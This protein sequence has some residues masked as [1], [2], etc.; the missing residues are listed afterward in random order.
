[1]SRLLTDKELNQ[2]RDLVLPPGQFD[3]GMSWRTILGTLF[4]ALVMLPAAMYMHLMIGEASLGPAATWVTVILFLEMAKRARSFLKPAVIFL[5]M[6]MI[7]MV[8]GYTPAEGFFWRQYLVQSD[9]VRSFGLASEFPTWYAPND[10]EVLD[11]QTFFHWA[12]FIPLV[13]LFIQQVVNKVDSLILGYGLFKL[14]SDIEKLP[15]PM[16][17]LQASGV[18]A[19]ADTGGREA[20]RWRCFSIATVIGMVFGLIYTGIPTITSTFLDAPYQ[21]LPIPWLDTTRQTEVWFPAT[22]TGMAFDLGNFFLGMAMPFFA[23]VGSF[24]GVIITVI[25]NPLLYQTGMLTTWRQG[26]SAVQTLFANNM[27]FYLSFSMGISVVIAAIGIYEV[28]RSLRSKGSTH[29][30]DTLARAATPLPGKVK[31]GDLSFFLVI[32]TYLISCS[33]YLLMAGYLLNWDFQ[34]SKLLW[35]LLFFSLIYVP[36]VSY[37]TA[38]LEGIAGQVLMIPYIKEVAFIL[39]GYRG[40]GIW[41]LPLPLTAN[42][43]IDTVQYR[44]AELIG[45]SFR[46]L[47]KLTAITIPLVFLASLM[48]GN[49][50]WSFGPI[51]SGS[52][53]YA[54]EMWDINARNQCLTFTAT[55]SGFS[56]FMDALKWQVIVAGAGAA[57]IAYTGLSALGLPIMLV[58]G[59]VR[60]INQSIPMMIFMQFGGALFGRYVMEAKF[61]PMWKKYALVLMPGF[62]CGAGLIMMFCTGIKFLKASVFQLPF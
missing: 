17:P 32:C 53:P 49:F 7:G 24:V 4:V 34:G 29:R 31:R 61:G 60:G 15:F 46:S 2:Y 13:I 9:A 38:R 35:V 40:L 36:F 3:E 30:L 5:L 45:C 59:S 56:P 26:D 6:A 19:L 48:Y 16:A 21:V 22:A 43:G 1:M 62:A 41:L 58:Y 12:W 44:V 14:T 51:P 27:D 39:S 54:Q 50:I 33:F 28:I 18:L 23:V 42:Y 10:L 47:W 20:W 8:A 25:L 55:A 11:Q 37:V 52:Y 57:A